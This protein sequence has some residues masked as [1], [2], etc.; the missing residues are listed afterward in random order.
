[1][2]DAASGFGTMMH[3]AGDPKTFGRVYIGTNGRGLV[4]FD[5][6]EPAAALPP[7]TGAAR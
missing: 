5:P 4:V 2:N 7:A 6:V 3:I 1:V